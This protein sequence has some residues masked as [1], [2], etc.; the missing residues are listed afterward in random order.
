[1]FEGRKTSTSD[2][3]WQLTDGEEAALGAD[4][5]LR[6]EIRNNLVKY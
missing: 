6:V 5:P 2:S 4:C 3:Q 1:M